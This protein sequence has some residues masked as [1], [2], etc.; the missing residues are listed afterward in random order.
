MEVPIFRFFLFFVDVA[1]KNYDVIFSRVFE[2]L[3]FLFLLYFFCFFCF[4]GFLLGITPLAL[5]HCVA[6]YKTL[7]L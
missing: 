7:G 5:G 3:D 4:F 2:N 1:T 6:I